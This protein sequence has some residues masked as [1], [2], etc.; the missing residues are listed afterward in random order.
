M[1]ETARLIPLVLPRGYF[2]RQRLP[3]ADPPDQIAD[4]SLA[5]EGP[6]LSRW[7]RTHHRTERRGPMT[8]AALLDHDRHP[9]G[10]AIVPA[11]DATGLALIEARWGVA[12]LG[13]RDAAY[14]NPL[15]LL[16][17]LFG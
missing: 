7:H 15:I 13:S 11:D 1:D 16:S 5:E 17:G 14:G 9:L 10:D 4:V 8:L 3:L 6:E 2:G 12:P